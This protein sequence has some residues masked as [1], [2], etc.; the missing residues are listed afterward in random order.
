M[1]FSGFKDGWLKA[2]IGIEYPLEKAR[3]AQTEVRE[4]KQGAKGKIIINI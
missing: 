3:E 4:H 1:S 2:V